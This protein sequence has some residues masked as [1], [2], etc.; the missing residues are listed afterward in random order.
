MAK[1]NDCFGFHK[2]LRR[3]YQ[4]GFQLILKRKCNSMA[5]CSAGAV[6]KDGRTQTYDISWCV[7]CLDT[8]NEI[9]NR[10]KIIKSH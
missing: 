9:E 6:D 5:L 3:L 10:E 1:M 2:V 4:L 8:L 7:L